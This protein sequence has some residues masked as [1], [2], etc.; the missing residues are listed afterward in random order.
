M[1]LTACPPGF[2]GLDCTNRCDTYCTGNESCDPV[3]GICTEGCKQGWSGL[4][5]GLGIMSKTFILINLMKHSVHFFI[6]TSVILNFKKIMSIRISSLH[7][8]DKILFFVNAIMFCSYF[9]LRL[10]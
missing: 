2:F 3:M 7:K 5:C 6:V 9:A 8:Y 10:S 4:M 1:F